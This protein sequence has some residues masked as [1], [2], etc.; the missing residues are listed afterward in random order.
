MGEDILGFS[1][2]FISNATV[3]VPSNTVQEDYNSI[4]GVLKQAVL[5]ASYVVPYFDVK[6][7]S[8]Y[9]QGSY[10]SKTNI[11]FQSKIEVIVE[12]NKT[13][14]FDYETMTQQDMKFRDDFFI[15]YDHYFDVRRFKQI[16]I[17]EL[18]KLLNTRLIIRPTT[19]LVPATSKLQHSIEIFPCF[20]YRFFND[21]GGSIRCKLV[22]DEKLDEHFLMFTNLHAVNGNLKDSMTRGNFKR[23]VRLMKNLVAISAREDKNIHSV[24]GYYVECL[25]YNVP[26]EMYYSN[27]NKL[28]SV[29]LKV[30]NWLNFANMSDFVCQNQI[31]SLWGN[32]DGFWD[33]H[34]AR[35]F[36]NDVIEFYE[37]FPDKRTEIIKEDVE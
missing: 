8:I 7:V 5:N 35:Q 6:D 10:A 19:I 30:I 25:L 26:N 1:E 29:F 18:K 13:R 37:A 16:L 9:L 14:E 2:E 20:K 32:A 15:D 17:D 27:D 33:Q 11:K 36:I 22:Y 24:R 12:L 23:I 21:N 34:S 31:W 28:L 4:E 3:E